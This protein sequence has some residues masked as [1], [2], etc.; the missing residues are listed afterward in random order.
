MGGDSFTKEGINPVPGA[1]NELVRDKQVAG[2][3]LLLKATR[4]ANGDYMLHP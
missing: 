1:V 4:R 3:Y 2:L